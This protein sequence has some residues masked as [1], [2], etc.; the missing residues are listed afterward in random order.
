MKGVQ[1]IS[2]K[3]ELGH[4]RTKADYVP[5]ADRE[6]DGVVEVI[7][8]YKDHRWTGTRFDSHAGLLKSRQ[9][10]NGKMG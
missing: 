3:T 7:K 6:W 1:I 10:R 8:P 5:L 9:K 4:S 2:R